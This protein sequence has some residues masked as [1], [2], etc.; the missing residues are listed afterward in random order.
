MTNDMPLKPCPCVVCGKEPWISKHANPKPLENL[1]G[2]LLPQRPFVSIQCRGGRHDNVL[3]N[4]NAAGDTI[5]AAEISAIT[6]WNKFHAQSPAPDS[7]EREKALE[8]INKIA[9][10]LDDNDHEVWADNLRKAVTVLT[11]P[12]PPMMG[13]DELLAIALRQMS[14]LGDVHDLVRNTIRALQSAGV[15]RGK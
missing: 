4:V 7:G 12:A 13:E 5:E 15:L 9:D 6:S 2:D 11:R 1:M 10:L 3:V 8:A 14:M